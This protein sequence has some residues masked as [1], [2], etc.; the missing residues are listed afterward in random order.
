M[1]VSRPIGRI[2]Y[3]LEYLPRIRGAVRTKRAGVMRG[4][5]RNALVFLLL[6]NPRPIHLFVSSFGLRLLMARAPAL[7]GTPEC[8]FLDNDEVCT[9]GPPL[10]PVLSPDE[11]RVA[12]LCTEFLSSYGLLARERVLMRLPVFSN[13]RRTVIARRFPR[14]L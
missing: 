5:R 2:G 9:S 13:T 14:S 1:P 12:R 3:T 11:T 4:T 6:G 8:Q 7:S 10:R